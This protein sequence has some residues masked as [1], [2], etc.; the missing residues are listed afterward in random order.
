MLEEYSEY[1]VVYII[2]GIIHFLIRYG[3]TARAVVKHNKTHNSL[4][5]VKI[6]WSNLIFMQGIFW[7][8]GIIFR[9]VEKISLIG[10]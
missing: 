3:I 2:S 8:I 1:I 6:K 9:I 10:V 4:N 7:P 5:Q